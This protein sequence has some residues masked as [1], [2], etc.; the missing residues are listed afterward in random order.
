MCHLGM[1]LPGGLLRAAWRAGTPARARL[2]ATSSAPGEWL[3]G[4]DTFARRHIGPGAPEQQHM[5]DVVGATRRGLAAGAPNAARRPSSLQQWAG[6]GAADE[7]RSHRNVV[8]FGGIH[9]NELLGI[10]VCVSTSAIYNTIPIIRVLA[11]CV[12]VAAPSLNRC[13]WHAGRGGADRVAELPGK[14]SCAGGHKR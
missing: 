11:E 2:L 6:T 14:R 12:G 13:W 3:G 5:L 4:C 9:G 8:V 7:R 10:Q 1:R